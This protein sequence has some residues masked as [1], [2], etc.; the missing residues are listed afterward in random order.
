MRRLGRAEFWLPAALLAL[1][2]AG[3]SLLL[4]GGCLELGLRDRTSYGDRPA[5][6]AGFDALSATCG[7]GLLSYDLEGQY[8]ARGRWLLVGL[9]VAGAV[10]YLAAMR[11][12]LRRLGWVAGG[13]VP[14]LWAILLALL[15]WQ[16]AILALVCGVAAARG[17][18]V[19]TA[20]W[21]AVATFASL[22]WLR[23][24]SGPGQ[25]WVYALA[26]LLSA[27]GWGVWL[28]PVGGWRRSVPL[29]RLLLC[30]GGYVA[31]LAAAAG[32][33]SALETQRGL[34]PPGTTPKGLSSLPAG[35]RYARCAVQAAC[36][37]GAG[38]AT[39]P[40]ADRGVSEGTK[41]VLAGL[42]VV[43]GLG[44][45]VGGG[46][47]WVVL[48]WALL[49]ASRRAAVACVA[50]VVGLVVVAALGLLIIEGWT[51]SSYQVAPTAADALLDAASAVAGGNLTTGL[52]A[53]VTGANLSRGIR[54]PVDLYQYGMSW[55]MVAMFIGRVLPVLVL[56]RFAGEG[57]RG[58][59]GRALPP[60][61][62]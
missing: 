22:G 52:T 5:W 31:L 3:N 17:G 58:V 37:A 62:Q 39:E 61:E 13:D 47:T 23:G 60:G 43:G 46:V 48:L 9:G 44:G 34:L 19:Q 10:L 57:G 50:W 28:L 33:M 45:T 41:L 6:Q 35:E 24:A 42:L 32:V 29:R 49:G 7:V 54:Q 11:Q 4:R 16:A 56:A 21:N 40:A 18:E 14:G 25:T 1:T 26:A 30:A 2:V 36:A 27:L 51:A 55:L 15:A 8:T 12:V 20:A 53:T 38:I 59:A